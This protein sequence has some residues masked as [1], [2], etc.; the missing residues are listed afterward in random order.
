MVAWFLLF[1][2]LA[3]AQE[4]ASFECLDRQG[5]I[6]RAWL[7]KNKKLLQVIDKTGTKEYP[8]SGANI[9]LPPK[10]PGGRLAYQRWHRNVEDPLKQLD[11]STEVSTHTVVD[12]GNSVVRL[13][14]VV[15]HREKAGLACKTSRAS[16]P[17][18][19]ET[20]SAPAYQRFAAI[21][22]DSASVRGPEGDLT[23]GAVVNV[24]AAFLRMF[25]SP[26]YSSAP[27]RKEFVTKIAP[28]LKNISPVSIALIGGRLPAEAKSFWKSTLDEIKYDYY[29]IVERARTWV[30]E[31]SR[32]PPYRHL[33]SVRAG[34]AQFVASPGYK[35]KD[36]REF[37][38]AEVLPSLKDLKEEDV[39]QVAQGLGKEPKAFLTSLYGRAVGK[40][41]VADFPDI[42]RLTALLGSV[43]AEKEFD[44]MKVRDILSAFLTSSMALNKEARQ[45]F[46][47]SA[48]PV[49]KKLSPRQREDV[50][51]WLEEAE[52]NLL[53][54]LLR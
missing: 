36:I 21:L 54:D 14:I 48:G 50:A 15:D 34:F 35:L 46:I 43:L 49:A 6:Y 41:T 40:R 19:P 8:L 16:V 31:G 52:A 9:G 11:P 23:S 51:G 33:P 17:V 29:P 53:R 5:T 20:E 12:K 42:D 26:D 47:K 1:N 38:I 10:E 45:L 39:D 3:F 18:L 4:T 44:P 13:G 27:A 2:A 28:H 32:P 25:Y 7:T 22:A 30:I 24:E 37:F